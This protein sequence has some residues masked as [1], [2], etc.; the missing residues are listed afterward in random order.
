MIIRKRISQRYNRYSFRRR[1]KK[2]I[3]VGLL[4]VSSGT[5]LII[6]Y[7]KLGGFILKSLQK[8]NFKKILLLANPYEAYQD[9]IVNLEIQKF[10]YK[11]LAINY[12]IYLLAI[13]V[14]FFCPFCF[15]KFSQDP[16]FFTEVAGFLRA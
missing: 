4:I 13:G 15:I 3:I 6:K 5:F 16:T 7:P 9:T 8:I 10:S 14:A 12:T 1:A 11:E 2:F